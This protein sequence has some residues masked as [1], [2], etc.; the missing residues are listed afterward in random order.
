MLRSAEVDGDELSYAARDDGGASTC[1]D[2]VAAEVIEAIA[3]RRDWDDDGSNDRLSDPPTSERTRMKAVVK[4]M[5]L[6][7]RHGLLS[8]W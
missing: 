7:A 6:V 4:I 8:L 5:V 2:T 3:C 1:N